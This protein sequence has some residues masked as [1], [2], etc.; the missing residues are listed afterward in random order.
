MEAKEIIEV[1]LAHEQ[2]SPTEFAN[3]ASIRKS[4]IS[5]Y[6]SG[7]VK[8]ISRRVAEMIVAAFPHYNLSWLLSGEGSML[9]SATAPVPEASASGVF[10]VD[11][12][13]S[14]LLVDPPAPYPSSLQE[15]YAALEAKYAALEATLAKKEAQI[16]TLLSLLNELKQKQNN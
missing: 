6:R 12:Y 9:S 5:E 16:D 7:K 10:G 2:L 15:R 11:D 4:Q 8:K 3:K 13:A 1:M 14:G